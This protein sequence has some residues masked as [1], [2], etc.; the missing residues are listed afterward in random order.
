MISNGQVL[1]V[2]PLDG[3]AERRDALRRS[4]PCDAPDGP[5]DA[6]GGY[7]AGRGFAALRRMLKDNNEGAQEMVRE[8]KLIW[9][10]YGQE[11]SLG[12]VDVSAGTK[13]V[14]VKGTTTTATWWIPSIYLD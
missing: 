11:V 1:F 6:R 7:L 3:T 2:C 12:S 14:R 4:A 13:E 5:P 8:G 10:D 9:L